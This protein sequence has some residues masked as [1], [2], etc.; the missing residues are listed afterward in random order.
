MTN[1]E[2][3]KGFNR[4]QFADWF[5]QICLASAGIEDPKNYSGYDLCYKEA[6]MWMDSELETEED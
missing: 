2:T 5:T 4:E 6:L 1:W 3:V